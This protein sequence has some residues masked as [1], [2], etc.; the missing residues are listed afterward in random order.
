MA[1]KEELVAENE[2]LKN[3]VA[4]LET[5]LSEAEAE[6]DDLETRTEGD[7]AHE[8]GDGTVKVAPETYQELA[9]A[10]A[11]IKT[12][13]EELR[14]AKAVE[15]DQLV[16]S[17]R[18][19]LV[20]ERDRVAALETNLAVREAHVVRLESDQNGLQERYLVVEEKLRNFQE[21]SVG[22]GR[23]DKIRELEE[24]VVEK[25]R[26]IGELETHVEEI[27]KNRAAEA[28][29]S[30]LDEGRDPG[31]DDSRV[32]ALEGEV[33]QRRDRIIALEAELE[34]KNRV[35]K[36]AL[37]EAENAKQEVQRL[38]IKLSELLEERRLTPREVARDVR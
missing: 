34:H 19:G 15:G 18:E 33:K 20:K 17:L 8:E 25:Q 23:V 12:L 24:L 26:R 6:V 27:G 5:K 7:G 13:H 14:K 28:G 30:S 4:D 32:T 31:T 38:H 3:K 29:S 1:T 35:A 10:R 37:N 9:D 16:I 36:D 2:S 22:Q 21:T 11:E